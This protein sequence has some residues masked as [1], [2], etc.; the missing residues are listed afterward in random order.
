[1]KATVTISLTCSLGDVNHLLAFVSELKETVMT[2]LSTLWAHVWH[3]VAA[4][5][6]PGGLLPHARVGSEVGTV[7]QPGV[8]AREVRFLPFADSSMLADDY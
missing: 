1:L 8:A 5:R 7:A 4:L 2:K 3:G 6:R